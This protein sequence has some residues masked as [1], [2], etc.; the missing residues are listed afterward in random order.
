MV[1]NQYS[2]PDAGTQSRDELNS[3]IKLEELRTPFLKMKT[4]KVSFR[5]V[6]KGV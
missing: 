4:S 6:I 3:F 5:E 1:E 2:Y